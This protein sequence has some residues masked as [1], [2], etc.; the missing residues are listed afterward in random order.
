MRVQSNIDYDFLIE[1]VQRRSE[2]DRTVIFSSFTIFD[3]LIKPPNFISTSAG[4]E[5][6]QKSKYIRP[7]V[8]NQVVEEERYTEQ[9]REVPPRPSPR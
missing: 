6:T 2:S 8:T 9:K 4:R 3:V 1:I 7:W 5:R